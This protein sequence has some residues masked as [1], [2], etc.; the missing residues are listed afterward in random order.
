MAVGPQGACIKTVRFNGL[1]PQVCIADVI[2]KIAGGWP[3]AR[4]DQLM[5]WNWRPSER[6][7]AQAA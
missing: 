2:D 4:G 1:E 3:A 6:D 7:V 5:S